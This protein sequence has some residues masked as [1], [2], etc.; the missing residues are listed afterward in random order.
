MFD[1]YDV[2]IVLYSIAIILL[3]VGFVGRIYENRHPDEFEEKEEEEEFEEE[4]EELIRANN[5][6]HATTLIGLS[7][8][9]GRK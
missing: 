6:H 2:A 9:N 5:A 4:E 7:H 1:G 8:I 3:L